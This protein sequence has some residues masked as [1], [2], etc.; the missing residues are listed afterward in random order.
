MG[1]QETSGKVGEAVDLCY[2]VDQIV[3]LDVYHYVDYL[4]R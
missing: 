4:L 3:N 1:R 2:S